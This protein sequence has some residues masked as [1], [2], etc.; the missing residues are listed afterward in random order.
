VLEPVE[1][2]QPLDA[3]VADHVRRTL[4][5]GKF[6]LKRDALGQEVAQSDDRL[7]ARLSQ[8][9]GHQVGQLS[10]MTGETARK[11]PEVE[12]SQPQ[13]RLHGQPVTT[14]AD[15][16]ALLRQPRG[17]QQAVLLHEILQRPEHRW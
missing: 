12:A 2:V 13:D 14:A 9:F 1:E 8:T 7:E 15:L 5:G 11:S 4:P 6:G 3:G 16:V 10:G 17:I